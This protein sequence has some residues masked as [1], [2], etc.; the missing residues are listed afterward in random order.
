MCDSGVC[1]RVMYGSGCSYCD[2]HVELFTS[3][4][5][6]SSTC[7]VRYAS[8]HSLLSSVYVYVC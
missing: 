4:R 2:L 7:I 6:L 1:D 8:V 3:C 5:Y